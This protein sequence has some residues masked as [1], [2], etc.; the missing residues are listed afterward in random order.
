MPL[1]LLE[2]KQQNT[3][4]AA[5]GSANGQPVKKRS[6][7]QIPG[8]AGPSSAFPEKA[9]T[10]TIITTR[11]QEILDKLRTANSAQPFLATASMWRDLGLN[12]YPTVIVDPLDLQT[13]S[14][15]LQDGSYSKTTGCPTTP[16]ENFWADVFRCWDNH[17]RY[18]THR[19]EE[20]LRSAE[21]MSKLSE[22][23]KAEFFQELQPLLTA[24]Q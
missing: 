12:D 23:L 2:K 13:I 21:D 11:L 17:I 8:A 7:L 6:T 24:P 3:S 19:A 10:A 9:T 14:R 4:V 15:R 22:G 20:A 18:F 16:A 5:A 1:P